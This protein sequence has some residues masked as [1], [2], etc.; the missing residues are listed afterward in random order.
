MKSAREIFSNNLKRLLDDQGIDQSKLADLVG[1]KQPTVSSWITTNKYPR[2]DTIVKIAKALNVKASDLTEE[3]TRKKTT[4]YGVPLVGT[5]AAGTPMLAEENIEDYFNLDTRLKADFALKIKGQSMKNVGI[6]DGDIAFFRQQQTLE[7]GQIGAILIDD[8]AT[9]KRFYRSN[10]TII[11]QAENENF[12]P[13][14]LEGGDVRVLGIL[15]ATLVR[16]WEKD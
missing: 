11:L 5:I 9:I 12:K 13:I 10:E 15:V 4:G 8:E 16:S 6:N 14:V 3:Q 1:V 2:I 7:N